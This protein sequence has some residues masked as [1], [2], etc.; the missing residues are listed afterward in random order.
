MDERYLNQVSLLMNALP[1]IAKE[2]CFSLKGGTAINLF[3]RNMPRLSVD[4]DLSYLGF[5]SRNEACKNINN[6]LSSIVQNLKNSGL[7]ANIQGNNPEK[8]IICS[9]SDATIKL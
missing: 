7:R 8:K 9:N 4:I 5:E 2:K 1:V 3:Y 6:A